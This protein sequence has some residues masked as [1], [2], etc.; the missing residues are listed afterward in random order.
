MGVKT[1]LLGGDPQRQDLLLPA[2]EVELLTVVEDHRQAHDP[3]R[4]QELAGRASTIGTERRSGPKGSINFHNP[5]RF[6]Q[7]TQ[8]QSPNNPGHPLE[9]PEHGS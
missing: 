2:A 5:R 6:P 7:R 1:A 4:Q 9:F 3:R 8:L